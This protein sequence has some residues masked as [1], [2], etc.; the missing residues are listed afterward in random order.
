M[1]PVQMM[2]GGSDTEGWLLKVWC[3]KLE[4]LETE[5]LTR[6]DLEATLFEIQ[7]DSSRRNPAFDSVSDEDVFFLL[8]GFF[9]GAL[10]DVLRAAAEEQTWARHKLPGALYLVERNDG[11]ERL[12]VLKSGVRHVLIRPAG[13]FDRELRRVRAQLTAR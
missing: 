9:Q 8:H 7:R 5:R 1:N 3:G 13:E 11:T 2:L 12:C 10:H 6:E 4:L